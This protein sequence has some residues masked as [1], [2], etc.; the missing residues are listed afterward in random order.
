MTTEIAVG[1]QNTERL[2]VDAKQLAKL[3]S[4]SVRT[5]RTMDAAARLPRPVKL[6]GHA[7]RWVLD[8]PQG[9]R[10]WLAAGAP[11]RSEFEAHL[12]AEAERDSKT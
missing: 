3:L 7:V 11:N 10:D 5:I 12:S 8:G 4:L 2:A 6:N 1:I 9:I